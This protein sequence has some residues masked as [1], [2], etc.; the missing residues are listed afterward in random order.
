[1]DQRTDSDAD[2]DIGKDLAERT[3]HLFF[4]IVQTV[5]PCQL[6]NLRFTD[7]RSLTDEIFDFLFHVQSF[8]DGTAN[9]GDDQAKNHIGHGNAIAKDTDEQ[10]QT[11]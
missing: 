1:M 11:A 8:Y 4:S 2:Q 10:H 5:A 7:S 9:N 6:W 3:G